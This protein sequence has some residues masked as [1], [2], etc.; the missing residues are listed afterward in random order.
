MKEKWSTSGKAAHIITAELHN[1]RGSMIIFGFFGVFLLCWMSI[2]VIDVASL[3][4]AARKIQNT[5]DATALGVV[6]TLDRTQESWMS[7]K[8]AGFLVLRQNDIYGAGNLYQT[9]D[10]FGTV[11]DPS[12]DGLEGGSEYDST[13]FQIANLHLNIERGYYG[14][15]DGEYQFRS[16]EIADAVTDLV[17]K[18]DG[19]ACDRMVWDIANAA[20]VQ[21]T[22]NNVPSYF[23]Q[24]FGAQG[25]ISQVVREAVSAKDDFATYVASTPCLNEGSDG[26]EDG[27]DGG[28]DE[29]VEEDGNGGGRGFEEV[30]GELVLEEFGDIRST[31]HHHTGVGGDLR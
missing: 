13:D 27:E 10:E 1:E 8:R 28:D 6:A 23:A 30:D 5:A 20:R 24:T 4:K 17:P 19:T 15:I 26:G 25:A 22:L 29:E 11:L 2:L 3:S 12:P 7:A 18:S 9:P 31:H 14:L 16:L 21:I